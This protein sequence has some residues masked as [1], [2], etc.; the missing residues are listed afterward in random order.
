MT[1]Y[2]INIGAFNRWICNDESLNN[3]NSELHRLQLLDNDC[4]LTIRDINI[5]K[6]TNMNTVTVQSFNEV[7]IN[8]VR[9]RTQKKNGNFATTRCFVKYYVN[10]ERR[11]DRNNNDNDSEAE[12]TIACIQKMY[13]LRSH[14]H[15]AIPAQEYLVAYVL[16]YNAVKSKEFVDCY[17]Q[18]S[19]SANINSS[20]VIDLNAICPFN[21]AAWPALKQGEVCAIQIN[22]HDDDIQY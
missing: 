21:V 4:Y 13:K 17:K 15:P 2:C 14:N 22:H 18:M 10:R 12:E 8:D 11:R 5:I 6:N 16:N 20:P 19:A 9:F 3:I 1:G 7:E